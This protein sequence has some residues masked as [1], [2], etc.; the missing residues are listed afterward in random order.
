[1]T[2]DAQLLS[3]FARGG[4]E[5]AF[6][7]LVARHLDLVYA[8]ALRQLN[9]DAHLAQ[10]V[11]QTVFTDLARK[12]RSLPRGAVLSGWL[13]E[14]ARFAAA[15]VVRGEQ[16]RRGREQEAAA[17]HDPTPEST[18][19]W[20]KLRPVLD[21]AMG[22]LSATD[23]NAVLLRFFERKDFRAVGLALGLSEDAAQKRVARALDK[24]RTDLA[25]RGVTLSATALAAA[26]TGG[27][28]HLAPAGLAVSVATA[29]LAG[30]SAAAATGF[31]A[32][33]LHAMATTK[34]TIIAA[35]VVAASVGAPLVMQY[36]A[37]ETLRAENAALREQANNQLA[38]LDE[39]QAEKQRLA[40]MLMD[41]AEMERFR[42]ERAELLR[43]RRE[44]T[45]LST[46]A[47]P[48]VGRGPKALQDKGRWTV[49][50]LHD[51]GLATPEA[52]IETWLAAARDGNLARFAACFGVK[53]SRP[54]GDPPMIAPMR[55][56]SV[57]D[58]F[59]STC[60]SFE[61][62]SM[63][64]SGGETALCL[65]RTALSDGDYSTNHYKLQKV[66]DDWR[67]TG[68]STASWLTDPQA[69]K[70]Q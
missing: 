39:L 63:N 26:I 22:D 19:D 7:E 47:R 21:T 31:A 52:V 34:A 44:V 41:P 23:R 69:T 66:G 13:Y 57:K 45:L 48:A 6:R 5:A 68:G 30:A 36:R 43:L 27:A 4:D 17:M 25:R 70:Q 35:A 33:L 1:M 51:A 54:P 9:G 37:N 10:D 28:I 15:K 46:T 8:A 29:S 3:R 61:V 64:V 60:R 11:A 32:N 50:T 14:A 24:L 62:L 20:E 58:A 55:I 59:N 16:R 12:A 53:D 56:D 18:P 2:D 38:E 65:I 42:D 49:D 67:I 40:K